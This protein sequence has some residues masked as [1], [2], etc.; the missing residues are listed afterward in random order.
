MYNDEATTGVLWERNVVV[1]TDSGGYLLHYGRNNTVRYNL[2]AYG[3]RSEVRV[4]RSDPLTKL[5]FNNN[6][7]IP[8]NTAPFVAF[9]TAPD[10]A[11]AGNSVSSR[12][13]ATPASLAMCGTGCATSNATL[14]VGADPRVTRAGHFLRASKLDE[15]PQLLDVLRGDMSLVG[16][17]P[18]VPQYVALYPEASRQK[19]LSVR[20]GITDPASIKFRQESELLARATDPQQEYLNVVM[21]AKLKL[22]EAYVDQ[23]SLALDFKIMWQTLRV[24]AGHAQP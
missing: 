5:A 10:V 4:T 22:A 7:L 13:L 16:P 21:P 1:G 9:A 8:K 15:L 19:I 24:L 2:L 14:T 17:R 18:E 23:S 11:Y 20:P 12:V 6:L 3:D